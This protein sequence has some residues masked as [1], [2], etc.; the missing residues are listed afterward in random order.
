MRKLFTLIVIVLVLGLSAFLVQ[1]YLQTNAKRT[2][3]RSHAAQG[4]SMKPLVGVRHFP[5]YPSN[6]HTVRNA[7]AQLLASGGLLTPV[8]DWSDR[9]PYFTIV[10]SDDAIEIDEDDQRV[11][12]QEIQLTAAS[13]IDYW[14]IEADWIE[15]ESGYNYALT[16]Y[17]SSPHK[18][19]LKHALIVTAETLAAQD[20]RQG[21]LQKIV[22][23]M[24]DPQYVRVSEKNQP[25]L[26]MWRFDALVDKLGVQAAQQRLSEFA[27]AVALSAGVSPYI[28]MMDLGS[29]QSLPAAADF[30]ARART[31]YLGEY[32]SCGNGNPYSAIM[33]DNA[34]Q[35][36]A[37]KDSNL[38]YIPLVTVG[39]DPRPKSFDKELFEF[40]N[41]PP[42][43]QQ[44]TPNE[45]AENVKAAVE[46]VKNNRQVTSETNTVLIA[47][48]MDI[49]ES[50]WLV[51]T[52]KYQNARLNA[53]SKVL[54]GRTMD[55]P[56]PPYSFGTLPKR[57]KGSIRDIAPVGGT[58]LKVNKPVIVS[59]TAPMAARL[60]VLITGNGVKR[61]T[62][63]LNGKGTSKERKFTVELPGLP[64]GGPYTLTIVGV[65][66]DPEF[67]DV[68]FSRVENIT[69]K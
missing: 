26:Y 57:E 22:K 49:T 30:S 2:E 52:R 25:L 43:C 47:A 20:W 23:Q 19:L 7:Q 45:I 3:L 60:K 54:G 4:R 50:G 58:V 31:S 1:T 27:G 36:N 62:I 5:G 14:A 40:G 48:W 15:Q 32:R 33:S 12:D 68:Q 37:N 65:A 9:W 18:S 56:A 10:R 38:N 17:N 66:K 59:G 44:G 35:W 46:W 8:Q 55:V 11:I 21:Y 41:D 53:I 42:W 29:K 61:E 64:A 39:M 51:P 16:L 69:V 24:K 67:N 6:N 34:N 13:G 28:V 63:F